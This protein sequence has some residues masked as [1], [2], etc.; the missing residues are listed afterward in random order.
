MKSNQGF[1][2]IELLLYISI[3]GTIA[4]S[5]STFLFIILQSDVKNRAIVEVEQ[6]GAQMMQRVTHKIRSAESISFPAS[7]QSGANLSLNNGGFNSSDFTFPKVAVS[8][9][10][11]TN[12]SKDNTPGIIRVQFTLSHNNPEN[13]QEYDYSKTFYGSASLR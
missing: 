9:L 12:L 1:T 11:F 5:I 8:N 7:G 6:Q 10:I 4:V 13:K 2:L 3:V